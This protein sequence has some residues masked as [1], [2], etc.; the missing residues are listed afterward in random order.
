M[1]QKSVKN[2]WTNTH[3]YDNNISKELKSEI[4]A[5]IV[6]MSSVSKEDKLAIFD[7]IRSELFG[8]NQGVRALQF[9]DR[10]VSDFESGNEGNWD[11]INKLDAADLLYVVCHHIKDYDI[12]LLSEQLNDMGTG[13]CPQGRTIRLIQIIWFL[14]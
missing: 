11:P 2:S 7:N 4:D 1:S 6:S 5:L 13:F 12:I 14:L 10:M 8:V 3:F 9:F